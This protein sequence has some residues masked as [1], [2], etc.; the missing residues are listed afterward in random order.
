MSTA[1]FE[2]GDLIARGSILGSVAVTSWLALAS[3][4]MASGAEP[5]TAGALDRTVATVRMLEG[6]WRSADDPLAGFE[7]RRAGSGIEWIGFRGDR[8][9]A[10]ETAAFVRECRGRA[11]RRWAFWRSERASPCATRSWS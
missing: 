7:V 2:R 10:P 9:I 8:A 5:A 3:A 6:R 1:F 4:G 11:W